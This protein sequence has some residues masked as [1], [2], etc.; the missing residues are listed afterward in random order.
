MTHKL[1]DVF[2][3]NRSEETKEDIW[4][5]FVVP[6]F[7]NELG[8]K[9]Q[10]KAIVII[11]GRGCGKT[12]LLRYFCHATQFSPKRPKIPQADLAHIGLYWRADTNF[13][14]SFA[15]GGQAPETWR[16]AFEH[17]LACEL[18]KEII[19]AVRNLNCNPERQ[20]TYGKIDE[21]DLEA[22]QDFD[23]A[24]GQTLN[25]L[26]RALQKSRRKM[27]TW[28]NNLETATRPIFLPAQL[29]LK[30][31]VE[32]LQ[33]Q[34]PYLQDSTFAVFIDEYENLRIEQQKFINGMLKHGEPPLLYN[35]AMKRNGW[36]TTQTLGSESI[37]LISDYRDIDLEEVVAKDF[38]L[39]AAE[40][41]FFRLA[42]HAPYLLDRLPI[43][44][45]QLRSVDQI[46]HR[47][48]NQEYRSRVIG[49]A[50]ELLP[51]TTD[52]GAA[53][54]I[55]ADHRLRDCLLARVRNALLMRRS[56]IDPSSFID[57]KYPEVSVLM[58][59]LLYRP[60]EDPDRL[61]AEFEALKSGKGGRLSP[62]GDL[63]G[64]NLFGCVNAIYID[65]RRESILFSGFTSLTLIARVNIRHLLELIH[66]IFK[67]F[68]SSEDC[69]L[70]EVPPE[71]QA[72]AVKDASELILGTVSGRGVHG[73]Q[74]HNLAQCLGSIFLERHKGSRQSEPEINHFT[75]SSGEMNDKL[76]TYLCEAE[77]W[78]VLYVGR[79][80]KMK[81]TGAIDVDYI[82]NPI[83]S[84]HFQISFRKKRSLPISASQLLGMLEG[85]QRVRDALVREFSHQ[86]NGGDDHPDLFG[87]AGS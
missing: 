43:V 86:D 82:L 56:R 25:D 36:H 68:E 41:L 37:Q 81:S 55:L 54:A 34:L 5:D 14:N 64:N 60:R 70:P 67:V 63:V 6:P 65:A 49:A 47:Y 11:G 38:D 24:L 48:K 84:P 26:E 22:L 30:T 7:L 69:E 51:R 72:K 3:K 12:T 71:V 20:R 19:Q 15:G 18:G 73:P 85:D 21:L 28:L 29:F 78:S 32:T 83:F 61:L 77:K 31:L 9:T 80:T 74:L 53:M 46:E 17:V 79:E 39:F 45:E 33:T 2:S 44:P 76:R 13:L 75:L 58:S 16:S 10:S 87:E 42:E 8:I 1:P 62:T 4:A 59:A 23:V 35:I 57:D 50:E 52:R 66:R 27:S 40:L